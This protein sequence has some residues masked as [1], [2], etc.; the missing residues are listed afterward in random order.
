MKKLLIFTLVLGIASV[1]SAALSLQINGNPD[2]ID[3]EI[4]LEPSQH[5]IIDVLG[6]G[7][8]STDGYP[9][10]VVVA[11]VADATIAGGVGVTGTLT[12]PQGGALLPFFPLDGGMGGV[13]WFIGDSASQTLPD[14][15]MIEAIDF[16]CEWG[17]ND[18]IIE[19]WSSPDFVSFTLED[20]AIIHQTPEPASLALLGLGGLLLRRRK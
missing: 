20:V 12:A 17:P 16:H 4:I 11:Q 18:V 15:V 3:S 14:G 10:V 2:P 5:A 1:A 13:D 8:N 6:A 19:L 9:Y 7:L